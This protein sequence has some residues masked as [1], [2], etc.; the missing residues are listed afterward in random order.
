M[1]LITNPLRR[2]VE[3]ARQLRESLGGSADDPVRILRVIEYVGPRWWVEETL[4]RSAT[5]PDRE[6]I[7]VGYGTLRAVRLTDEQAAIATTWVE[8]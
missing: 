2:T 8:S 7:A 1:T 3:D 5:L 4:L 6:V